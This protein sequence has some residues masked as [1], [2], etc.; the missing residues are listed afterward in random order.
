[1]GCRIIVCAIPANI[2]AI[3]DWQLAYRPKIRPTMSKVCRT[4]ETPSLD[5][6]AGIETDRRCR[7]I[8]MIWRERIVRIKTNRTLTEASS[9]Q[10]VCN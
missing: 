8:R 9:Y 10:G 3:E 5:Q 7:L 1:M 4:L 6:V 2:V